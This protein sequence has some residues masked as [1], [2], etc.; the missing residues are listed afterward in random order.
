MGKNTSSADVSTMGYGA[1]AKAGL[2][3][4]GMGAG[5]SID[6]GTSH[7]H[8]ENRSR[9]EI[10][11]EL[12]GVI[13]TALNDPS[14]YPHQPASPQAAVSKGIHDYITKNFDLAQK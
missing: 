13:H 8:T 1:N 5:V 4:M 9:D 2:E 11:K 7:G 3:F 14:K 6:K 10:A 12:R